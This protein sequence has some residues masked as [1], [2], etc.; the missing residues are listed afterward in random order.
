MRRAWLGRWSIF[1]VTATDNCS[2]RIAVHSFPPSGSVFP[3]GQTAVVCEAIDEAGNRAVSG[4][5]VVVRPP[6]PVQ[7]RP[8]IDQDVE[9]KWDYIGQLEFTSTLTP[10]DWQPWRGPVSSNGLARSAILS[11]SG[12]QVYFRIVRSEIAPA[13]DSDGDGVADFAVFRKGKWYVYESGEPRFRSFDFG[14]AD[15]LPL[16]AAATK[17]VS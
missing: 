17:K 11:S 14:N 2:D 16:N 13:A 6:A 5:S 15:D 1:S 7:I 10:P 12:S 8:A 3:V 9:V 4:F